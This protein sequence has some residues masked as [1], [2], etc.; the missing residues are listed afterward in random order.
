MSMNLAN[1]VAYWAN[2]R[3]NQTAA[4]YKG[5]RLTWSQLDQKANAVAASLQELGVQPGDRVGCLMANNLHWVVAWAAILKAGAVLVPLNPRYGDG[6]LR[7]IAAMVNC[8]VMVSNAA[9][10]SRLN[11]ALTENC[12]D[13][14]S[15]Q[16]FEMTGQHA[17]VDYVAAS[18]QQR[19]PTATS[20]TADD[21]AIITFTSGSTG[22]PKGAVLT[23][24]ALDA[25]TFSMTAAFRY[26]SE[27]RFLLL[28]PFAFTGGFVCVY[29]PA[30]VLGACIYIEDSAD[31]E[32]ALE[33]ITRERVSVLM[34]VPILWERMANS[35]Q[36][37]AADLSSLKVTTTGGAP[38]PVSLLKQYVDKGVH[39]VQTYGC[40][41][42]S[43]FIAIPNLQE[44]LAKPWS[45][46]GAI[47]S[48]ELNVLNPEGQPCA[49]DEVGEI[50][51]R[52]SQ[53]F[54]GYWNA[55]QATQ[56]AWRNGWYHTGDLGRLDESGHV[57]ITDRKKNMVI[58]GG[59]NVY[60]AEVE[61]AM[62]AIAGVEEV[63]AF[64]MPDPVWDERVVAV[65]HGSQPIDPQQIMQQAKTALGAYKTP[66]E[67]I[68]SSKPLP[69]TSSGK[70]LRA[71]FKQLYEQLQDEPR[72]V[73][74]EANEKANA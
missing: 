45:C 55:P 36:F 17:P 15:I 3:G 62:S 52:G 26:T 29:V 68:A 18:N 59:V 27:D 47:L 74:R 61:R 67:I 43:G 42:A 24:K 2:M 25:V 31:P 58:S 5:E 21:I 57:Q 16:L 66:K 41:E 73:A 50:V 72:A 60:P 9:Q 40:T 11:S 54:S 14:Q 37:A 65:V 64:G 69:R 33:T 38:V 6:E 44:G 13:A 32:R 46:G 34:G 53:M 56:E 71:Q 22:L 8:K 7:E 35:P 4:V 39:I 19:Q 48:L 30:F 28:A 12:S 23:H 49:T 70:V 63:I 10:I 20:R 1:H 51:L